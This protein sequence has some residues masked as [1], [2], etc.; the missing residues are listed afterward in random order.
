MLSLVPPTICEPLADQVTYSPRTSVPR[1]RGA[2]VCRSHRSIE[3]RPW[4][5]TSMRVPSSDQASAFTPPSVR[6][7][8]ET[9]L[10]SGRPV[11]TCHSCTK[12]SSKPAAMADPSGLKASASTGFAGLMRRLQLPPV[13][14]ATGEI[15]PSGP[16]EASKLPRGAQARLVTAPVCPFEFAER[17]SR[18]LPQPD[19]R[20]V[21]ARGQRLAVG[22]PGHG[23]DRAGVVL[24]AF[25]S[26]CRTRH[27]TGAPFCRSR[28]WPAVCRRDS[29]ATA[30]MLPVC[31]ASV[32]SDWAVT[33][34]QST[35]CHVPR[36]V[37]IGL[38]VRPQRRRHAGHDVLIVLLARVGLRGGDGRVVEGKDLIGLRP[39]QFEAVAERS[40]WAV[41]AWSSPEACPAAGRWP[42]TA[43]CRRATRPPRERLRRRACPGPLPLGIS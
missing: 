7:W 8:S 1:R 32:C 41:C 9:V 22:R 6:R 2:E 43:A 14:C 13:L 3:R 12:P 18:R 11:P 15:E 35:S 21:A 24:A 17:L 33:L 39:V 42:R 10:G 4:Q 25:A 28:P 29:N 31:P 27:P 37:T 36:P 20:V 34:S 38:P 5:A 30:A 16:P 40:A 23:F 26:S 19:D